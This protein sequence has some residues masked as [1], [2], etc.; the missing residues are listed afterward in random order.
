MS[1]PCQDPT[2]PTISQSLLPHVCRDKDRDVVQPVKEVRPCFNLR[3]DTGRLLGREV[4]AAEEFNAER[5]FRQ[6]ALGPDE[7]PI[8]EAVWM[9]VSHLSSGSLI[10]CVDPAADDLELCDHTFIQLLKV[11]DGIG[12]LEELAAP[13]FPGW[14][15]INLVW[16]LMAISGMDETIFHDGSMLLPASGR[17]APCCEYG[18]LTDLRPLSV[19]TDGNSWYEKQGAIPKISLG[20][21]S[22]LGG[23]DV[24]FRSE[25]R[26]SRCKDF[27]RAVFNRCALYLSEMQ[28]S[29]RAYV[30]ACNFLRSLPIGMFDA[31]LSLL[32]ERYPTL[33]KLREV[34]RQAALATSA[35]GSLGELM[36][37]VMAKKE[38]GEFHAIHHEIRDRLV[39]NRGTVLSQY[40][41][42]TLLDDSLPT[43]LSCALALLVVNGF[44]SL[45]GD[46]EAAISVMKADDDQL[47]A[48]TKK[49]CE[50]FWKKIV[51]AVTKPGN[52]HLDELSKKSYEE[53]WK[54]AKKAFP[55]TPKPPVNAVLT[56]QIRQMIR[57]LCENYD[58]IAS[59]K[60]YA[61]SNRVQRQRYIR[62]NQ[63]TLSM[64]LFRLTQQALLYLV[65]LPM[66]RLSSA[67]PELVDFLKTKF[68]VTEETTIE[69]LLNT[70]GA[71]EKEWIMCELLQGSEK[72]LSTLFVRYMDHH[73]TERIP[74]ED[75]Y[76]I[77][78][79]SKHICDSKGEFTLKLR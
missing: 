59:V 15:A 49:T 18:A 35:N 53:I 70:S 69:E 48:M 33:E 66:A 12:F 37:A 72:H 52:A 45:E 17:K 28:P 71:S 22:S 40:I 29:R 11:Q 14:K 16:N 57:W 36:R 55:D 58:E 27:D 65:R 10:E 61:N 3:V 73:P 9:R 77:F 74:L 38:D 7:R 54:E 30:S 68:Q 47:E 34:I 32:S 78:M 63:A 43:D 76:P 51:F 20:S 67:C 79:L 2:R 25:P 50:E 46:V 5:H 42:D 23:E 13:S 4:L 24:V 39:S 21:F 62:Y 75:L 1:M 19:F 8:G 26:L 60:V 6:L 44:I 64:D 56:S 31:S 41:S